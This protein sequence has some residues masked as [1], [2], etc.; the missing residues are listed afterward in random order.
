MAEIGKLVILVFKRLKGLQSG[1]AHGASEPAV[2]YRQ[3][4][5]TYR[6][7]RSPVNGR[8]KSKS[9]QGNKCVFHLEGAG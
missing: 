9:L 5:E 7:A 8:G 2:Q 3:I 6:E 1:R 4:E